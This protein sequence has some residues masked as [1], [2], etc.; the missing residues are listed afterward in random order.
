MKIVSW[1]V[2]GIRASY[3]KGLE[4]FVRTY[5]PDVLCLQETKANPDQLEPAVRELA[6]MKAE[7][8]SASKKGYSGV[9]T[10]WTQT[11][12][13]TQSGMGI[14]EFDSE[15]RVVIMKGLNPGETIVE[16]GGI[17]LDNQIDLSH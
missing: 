6:G 13:K 12:K 5:K 9:A 14:E 4:G 2:N 7:W 8:A 10:F 16:Q 11:P 1:N 17:L 15:G 3:K